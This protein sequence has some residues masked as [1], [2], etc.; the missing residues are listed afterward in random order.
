MRPIFSTCRRFELCSYASCVS[1]PFAKRRQFP[2]A[3]PAITAICRIT[4]TYPLGS[5]ESLRPFLPSL[6][7]SVKSV[8]VLRRIEMTSERSAVAEHLALAG[9]AFRRTSDEARGLLAI[10][11][12]N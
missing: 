6:E 12:Y 10:I 8:G 4:R 2:P 1:E 3:Q 7:S 5:L 9:A 11:L